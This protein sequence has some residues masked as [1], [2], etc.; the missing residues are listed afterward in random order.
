M[1]L[2]LSF[3]LSLAR[4]LP[5]KSIK[6]YPQMRVKERTRKSS[7]EVRGKLRVFGILGAT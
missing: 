5:F 4:S 2:S 1:S 6:T 3:S 7:N